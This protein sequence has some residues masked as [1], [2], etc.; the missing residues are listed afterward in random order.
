MKKNSNEVFYMNQFYDTDIQATLTSAEAQIYGAY[1]RYSNG[2]KDKCWPGQEKLSRNLG[3]GVRTVT[4]VVSSLQKK[5]YIVLIKRGNDRI[6]NSVFAVRT[7][8]ELGF[9]VTSDTDIKLSI[10][11]V[12]LSGPAPTIEYKKKKKGEKIEEPITHATILSCNMPTPVDDHTAQTQVA[13]VVEAYREENKEVGESVRVIKIEEVEEV[14]IEAVNAIL[15]ESEMV[16][17]AHVYEVGIDKEDKFMCKFNTLEEFVEYLGNEKVEYDIQPEE[18]LN[19][20]LKI[21]E[22]GKSYWANYFSNG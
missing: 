15:S 4:R 7:P 12:K 6:G 16:L 21:I 9:I 11:D 17:A 5:G 14:E 13:V 3:L 22:G 20:N 2:G 18:W 19:T 8:F 10:A 1:L